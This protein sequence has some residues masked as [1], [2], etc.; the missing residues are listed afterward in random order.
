MSTGLQGRRLFGF[1]LA[2]LRHDPLDKHIAHVGVLEAMW[3]F[4]PVS[5]RMLSSWTI[6]ACTA[7]PR[8]AS[9]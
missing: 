2:M 9:R 6:R 8:K 3:D 1:L 5:V 4:S 7:L